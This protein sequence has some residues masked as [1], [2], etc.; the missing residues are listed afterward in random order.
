MNKAVD[1][2]L[3]QYPFLGE[4]IRREQAKLNEYIQLQQEARDPL[5]ARTIYHMPNMKEGNVSDKTLQAIEKVI[6]YYQAKIDE[7]VNKIN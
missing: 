6:D 2:I 4:D 1:E 5:K 3:K 7:Q